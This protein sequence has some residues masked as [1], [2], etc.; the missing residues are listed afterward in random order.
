ML[1][2]RRPRPDHGEF[3]GDC[4]QQRLAQLCAHSIITRGQTCLSPRRHS[5]ATKGHREHR[6]LTFLTAD[7]REYT[8]MAAEKLCCERST[9]PRPCRPSGCEQESTAAAL[10][11]RNDG[12]RSFSAAYDRREDFFMT[13]VILRG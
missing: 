1:R 6:E 9:R 2:G 11:D 4:V 7:A 12:R 3:C 13:F 8:Q 10:F 5:L